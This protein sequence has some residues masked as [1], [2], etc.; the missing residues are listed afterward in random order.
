V[1]TVCG[2]GSA[3]LTVNNP[4]PIVKYLPNHGSV[5]P[6]NSGDV[7]SSNPTCPPAVIE[8]GSVD[9]VTKSGTVP[10]WVVTMNDN[11]DNF[12]GT[13]TY[14]VTAYGSGDDDNRPT[15]SA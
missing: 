2:A 14:T 6:A 9:P 4:N 5:L 7:T 11:S 13:F 15:A 12:E 10:N 8:V 3:T 1:T